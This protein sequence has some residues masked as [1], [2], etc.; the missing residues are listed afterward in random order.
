[1]GS[2][3][4][5]EF[6][7]ESIEIIFEEP[8]KLSLDG[9]WIPEFLVNMFV[10]SGLFE[11]VSDEQKTLGCDQNFLLYSNIDPKISC[12]FLFK[13]SESHFQNVW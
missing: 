11:S 6:Q 7:S 3:I 2:E 9:A 10:Y 1:M 4:F 12:L 13:R 8:K 5:P